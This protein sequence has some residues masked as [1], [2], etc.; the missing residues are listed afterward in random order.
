MGVIVC[1]KDLRLFSYIA[2]ISTSAS[3][4]MTTLIIWSVFNTDPLFLVV[5]PFSD[6]KKF[7]PTQLL[8]LV[9]LRCNAL[10]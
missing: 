5:S 7:P 4:V 6:K 8:A 3:N 10:L 2:L 9:S 1:G